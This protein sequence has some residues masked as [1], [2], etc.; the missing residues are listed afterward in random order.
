MPL[1]TNHRVGR[2]G[3]FSFRLLTGLLLG[4]GSL[5]IFAKL[6]EGILYNELLVIDRIGTLLVRGMSSDQV[7]IFMRLISYLGSAKFMGMI[8]LAAMALLGIYRRHFWD[9]VL[10]PV[11]MLGGTILNDVLK[12]F[13]QR[14]RPSLPHLVE[15]TGFSFP[16]GH[17]MMSFVFYGMLTYL[18]WLNFPG[19]WIRFTTVSIAVVLVLLIGLSRIY[20]G[21]HYPSDVLAGFAA[22]SF[23]LVACILG[24]KSIR[25][26]KSNKR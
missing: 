3:F 16:S 12:Y 23:W 11:T 6:S 2:F 26:Y 4:M 22:G 19:R 10:V 21:V 5:V 20:L 1:I 15:A 9:T 13:F 7:T 17:A 25:L 14:E 18:I 8:A 24:L